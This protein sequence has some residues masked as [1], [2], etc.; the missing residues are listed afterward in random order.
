MPAMLIGMIAPSESGVRVA[1][2]VV[3]P[4][5]EQRHHH[6]PAADPEQAREGA[7]E[8]SDRDELAVD[9]QEPDADRPAPEEEASTRIAGPTLADL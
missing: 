7:A 3:G 5:H 1:L 2:P 9:P 8:Q 4:E 6:D